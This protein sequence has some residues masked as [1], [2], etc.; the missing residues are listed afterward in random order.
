M[1]TRPTIT[2]DAVFDVHRVVHPVLSSLD[3][4]HHPFISNDCT[5]DP[6]R[7]WVVTGP[8]MGGVCVCVC[9]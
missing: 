6:H 3:S 9:V 5:M 7:V 1:Y 2:S 4:V 8:N